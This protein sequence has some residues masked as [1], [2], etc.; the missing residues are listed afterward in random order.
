MQVLIFGAENSLL[1]AQYPYA[2]CYNVN[3]LKNDTECNAK[4]KPDVS[5][6]EP[7]VC[8]T[9]ACDSFEWHTLDGTCNVSCGDGKI[10]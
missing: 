10:I 8:N 6:I 7:K 2:A 9:K 4:K 1:G 3:E 5:L